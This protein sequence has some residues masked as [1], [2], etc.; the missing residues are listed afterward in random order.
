MPMMVE[1]KQIQEHNKV[2]TKIYIN[3]GSLKDSWQSVETAL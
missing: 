2:I 1:I 3:R